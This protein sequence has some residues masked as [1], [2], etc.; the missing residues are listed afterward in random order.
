MGKK[1]TDRLEAKIASLEKEASE[2]RA[3]IAELRRELAIESI[4]RKVGSSAISLRGSSD[5]SET[6]ALLFK[7]LKELGIQTIRCGVGLFDEDSD[8]MELWLTTTSSGEDPKQIFDY[9]NLHIHPVYEKVISAR[10]KNDTYTFTLLKGEQVRHFY[11]T[12]SIY[13]AQSQDQPYNQEE[14]F[15]WFFFPNGA[16]YLNSAEPLSEQD[17]FIMIRFA[18]IYGQICLRFKDLQEVEKHTRQAKQ[19]SALNG[20]RAEIASMHTADDLD[21]I[22]PMLW[23]VLVKLNVPFIRCGLFIIDQ[24]QQLVHA[25]LSTPD[26]ESIGVLHLPFDASE[27]IRKL[28]TYWE[29]QKI[30][31]EQWER[32]EF[33]RWVKS[34]LEQGQIEGVEEFM[35]SDTSYNILHL[36]FVP[37]A[38][39][40]LYVGSRESLSFDD[41]D[42]TQSLA[43]A[44]SVA[45]ARHL[46][47][48]QLE[49]AKS[50]LQ[51]AFDDLK[52]T[53]NQLIHSE[54][55]A[56][57]GELTAGIAHEIK[58]PL[59][60]VHNFS[61]VSRELLGELLEEV[62][63]GHFEE[64]ESIAGDLVQNLDKIVHH[65]QRADSIVKGML[66]HSRSS[67][68]EREP[69]DIN[70]LTDE[71]LRLAY[72][73]LRA[74][75]KS[76]NA[77]VETNFE[78]GIGK[79]KVVPQDIGRVLLNLLTNAFHAVGEKAK[80]A[81]GDFTPT[82]KVM[83]SRAKGKVIISVADNGEGIPDKVRDKIFQPF[84]T[85]K[86]TGQGTGLGLSLSYDILKAHGG[87]ISVDSE[88]GKGTEFIVTLPES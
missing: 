77:T 64:V 26:A 57:L 85:T 2:N 29:E 62:K 72:H 61:E 25:Y 78:D 9:F 28:V 16:L 70:E 50:R 73:G 51:K 33:K 14:Y 40:M 23:N 15:Y 81:T 69:T 67:D 18:E 46:D 30:Y 35:G 11:Q 7:N 63:K 71:Y 49:D 55:M 53:Q 68:G 34:L 39:G 79:I 22:T 76:F 47:F 24:E 54:K 38:Q 1:E 42:L 56:S 8:A 80:G 41:V 37:F 88:E 3:L 36:Q 74:R 10:K 83:T 5:L 59:N 84:F 52:A 65:G 17:C 32:S 43:E 48:R 19:Q 58:N 44:F 21:Q 82:V 4:L 45:Y 66:Q 13:L 20:I 27:T 6:S 60:F 87:G 31:R 75:D 12:T 86:P